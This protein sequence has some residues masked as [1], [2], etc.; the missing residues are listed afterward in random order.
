[1]PITTQINKYVVERD[2]NSVSVTHEAR[3]LK[4]Y[5]IEAMSN[6]LSHNELHD[7]LCT[8]DMFVSNHKKTDL[9][10]LT[11]TTSGQV[12]FVKI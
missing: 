2:G 7:L 1:M 6:L 8:Y 4:R 5:I 12:M 9:I 3:F 11:I 10:K